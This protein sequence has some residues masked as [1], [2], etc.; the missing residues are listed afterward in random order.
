M[1]EL[2]STVAPPIRLTSASLPVHRDGGSVV[3]YGLGMSITRQDLC[4]TSISPW[5]PRMI[6]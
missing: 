6:Y 3:A 2:R 5:H 1:R 4:P